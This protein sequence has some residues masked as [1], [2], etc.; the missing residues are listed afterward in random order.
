MRLKTKEV[1]IGDLDNDGFE[2]IHVVFGFNLSP[3]QIFRNFGN[4]TFSS[5]IEL[6]GGDQC[7]GLALGGVNND[8]KLD[9]ISGSY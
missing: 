4:G 7:D 5:P 1:A 8:G 2:D 9:I 6:P 3:L